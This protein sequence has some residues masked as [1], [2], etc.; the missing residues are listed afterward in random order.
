MREPSL[1]SGGR[2]FRS[3]IRT[4]NSGFAFT[5]LGVHMDAWAYKPGGPNVFKINGQVHHRIGSLLPRPG[6]A[7]QFLQ[8]YLHG[9]SPAQQ[10]ALRPTLNAEVCRILSEV[11][12]SHNPY[13]HLFTHNRNRLRTGAVD[14]NILT[15]EPFAS[16]TRRYNRPRVDEVAAIV[17]TGDPLTSNVRDILVRA[18]DG[19]LSNISEFSS[20]YLPLQYP[21]IL[22]YGTHG[23][24]KGLKL[25]RYQGYLN[26]VNNDSGIFP[27]GCAPYKRL[28]SAIFRS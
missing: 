13:V 10:T 3:H 1:H 17:N 20:T 21:L 11:M 5:S 12:I 22:P 15:F 26:E 7:P 4:F 18:T 19:P 8:L 25:G 23:W 14:L 2:A 28:V 16:D 9:N 6:D 24:S 27:M